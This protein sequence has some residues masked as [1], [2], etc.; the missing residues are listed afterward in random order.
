[1]II[2]GRTHC[3]LISLA[4]IHAVI[5]PVEG[6]FPE[7]NGSLDHSAILG[8]C[9][10][11]SQVFIEIVHGRYDGHNIWHATVGEKKCCILKNL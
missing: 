11:Q 1:V 6:F 7:C 3:N 9:C 2:E 10:Y 8:T 5:V 4:L